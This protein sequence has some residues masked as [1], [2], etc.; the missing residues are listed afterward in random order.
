M[1]LD[2]VLPKNLNLEFERL[3]N[4]N[5]E[6]II[7]NSELADNHISMDRE[8]L[9]IWNK[10][11]EW[12]NLYKTEL[13]EIICVPESEISVTTKFVS[14]KDFYQVKMF[15]R[16]FDES[17]SINLDHFILLTINRNGMYQLNSYEFLKKVTEI[18][19][20]IDTVYETLTNR[21]HKFT[22]QLDEYEKIW[23]VKLLNR[24]NKRLIHDIE[25]LDNVCKACLKIKDTY[26]IQVGKI[27]NNSGFMFSGNIFKTTK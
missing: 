27:L 1:L 16:R 9:S 7:L 4:L 11:V 3:K 15:I 22:A 24:Q 6:K 17:T 8:Y 19:N 10:L 12:L 13:S 14:E 23:Y 20:K 18:T 2:N 5:Q 21:S 26:S 25:L